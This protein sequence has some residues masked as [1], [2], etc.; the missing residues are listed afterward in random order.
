LKKLAVCCVAVLVV[1]AACGLSLAAPIP[2]IFD[3]DGSPDAVIALLYLTA[4]PG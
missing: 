2:L 1:I 3:D 4:K